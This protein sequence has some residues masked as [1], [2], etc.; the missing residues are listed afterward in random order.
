MRYPRGMAA[1]SYEIKVTKG[2]KVVLR[3]VGILPDV[4]QL[5]VHRDAGTVSLV[6]GPDDSARVVLESDEDPGGELQLVRKRQGGGGKT[7][8]KAIPED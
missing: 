2:G 1:S 6:Y 8:T 4:D 3:Y 5:G 7:V